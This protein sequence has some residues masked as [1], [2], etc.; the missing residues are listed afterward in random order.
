MK[1]LTLPTYKRRLTALIKKTEIEYDSHLK[2]TG[3]STDQCTECA[4]L[5]G[6]LEGLREMQ[7]CGK[8]N[9]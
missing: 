8:A 9:R 4:R 2:T 3:G 6:K 5:R 1:P 7:K